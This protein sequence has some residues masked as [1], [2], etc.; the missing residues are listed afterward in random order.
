MAERLLR[1]KPDSVAN[2][3]T[4]RSISDWR[5]LM[6]LATEIGWASS[7]RSAICSGKLISG[8]MIW[9]DVSRKYGI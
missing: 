7:K 4:A 8:Y 5:A 1:T 2:H 6:R 9:Y 3:V